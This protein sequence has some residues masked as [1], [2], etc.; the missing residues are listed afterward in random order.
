MCVWVWITEHPN[1]SILSD[2]KRTE[3]GGVDADHS[4]TTYLV[5]KRGSYSSTPGCG[6]MRKSWT[7]E[8]IRWRSQ[9]KTVNNDAA[10]TLG[11]SND[12]ENK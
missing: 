9:D 8:T 1:P 5:G 4:E 11:G 10:M 7:D 3:T 12:P 2:K 6:D